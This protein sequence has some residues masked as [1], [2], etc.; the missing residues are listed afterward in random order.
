MVREGYA[1]NKGLIGVKFCDSFSL[2]L[3]ITAVWKTVNEQRNVAMYAC[4]SPN[5]QGND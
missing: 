4:C 5:W 1:T 2:R 3:S